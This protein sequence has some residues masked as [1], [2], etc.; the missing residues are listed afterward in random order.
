MMT[1]FG[2]M[3]LAAKPPW[4]SSNT[5]ANM[6]LSLLALREAAV[7]GSDTILLSIHGT[8]LRHGGAN[9]E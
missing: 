3:H 9:L 2:N 4:F 8:I 1:H 5:R 6:L 7:R